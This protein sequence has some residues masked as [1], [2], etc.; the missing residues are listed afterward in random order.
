M[1]FIFFLH[2]PDD[3]VVVLVRI[4]T[5]ASLDSTHK[6]LNISPA[7]ADAHSNLGATLQELGQIN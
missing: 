2:T 4:P 6:T 5:L 7:Y 1:P 3:S